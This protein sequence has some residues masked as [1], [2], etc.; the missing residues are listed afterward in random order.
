MAG[1]DGDV[2]VRG[3]SQDALMTDAT[4]TWSVTTSRGRSFWIQPGISL[5]ASRP[6]KPMRWWWLIAPVMSSAVSPTQAHRAWRGYDGQSTG[7]SQSAS[8]YLRLAFGPCLFCSSS[9]ASCRLGKA[10]E[11][12]HRERCG[13]ASSCPQARVWP[14]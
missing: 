11:P 7:G 9:P 5:Q 6:V 2:A 10:E 4:A 12:L 8:T 13:G 1:Y 14:W 3:I